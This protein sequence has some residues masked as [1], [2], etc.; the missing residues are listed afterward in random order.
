MTTPATR[1]RAQLAVTRSEWISTGALL[2]SLASIIWTGG[3][4]Y[5]QV[6]EHDR[7][8]VLVEAKMDA[9]VPRL[10]RIDA[11]V[12]I[13]AQRAQEDRAARGVKP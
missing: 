12:A 9:I 2:V 7:R 4:I 13:L 6:Q 3:V 8:I 5:G 11:N 1:E 10:E